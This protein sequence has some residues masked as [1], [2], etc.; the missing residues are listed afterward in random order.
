[1][2]QAKPIT[3]FCL[4]R[5]LASARTALTKAQQTY[6]RNV[7]KNVIIGIPLERG[8]DASFHRPLGHFVPDEE[9]SYSNF[10]PRMLGPFKVLK[11]LDKTVQIDH[12]G[13][14]DIGGRDRCTNLLFQPLPSTTT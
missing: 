1:M 13:L 8:D 2:A 3:T 5:Y 10:L 7:F 4:K 9:T 6:R 12:N 14:G 11:V